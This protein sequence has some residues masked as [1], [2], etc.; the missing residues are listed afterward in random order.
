MNRETTKKITALGVVIFS[1]I[2]MGIC[3]AAILLVDVGAIVEYNKNNSIK[4][5]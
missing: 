5:N 2:G 3:F 4:I 1:F